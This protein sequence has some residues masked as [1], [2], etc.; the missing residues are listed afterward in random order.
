MAKIEAKD[1]EQGWG[2]WGGC[3]EPP[4]HQLDGQGECWKLPQRGPGWSSGRNRIFGHEKALKM[5][6]VGITF[7]SF[8]AQ[9]CIHN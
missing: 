6:I 8:T 1:Q 4:S 3:N 9:I 5:Y 7:V 2:F